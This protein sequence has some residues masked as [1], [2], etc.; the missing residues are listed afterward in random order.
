[1]SGLDNTSYTT[2]TSAVSTTLTANDSV[3]LTTAALTVTLP[4]ADVIQPGR[5]YTVINNGTGAVTFATTGGDT[6]NGGAAA[7]LA[8]AAFHAVTFVS[9]GLNWFEVSRY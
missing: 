3:L 7:S 2:R 5:Q 6:V 9:N 8:A 4:N 1:M